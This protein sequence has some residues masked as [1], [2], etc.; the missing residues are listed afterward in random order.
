MFDCKEQ[1]LRPEE[2][3]SIFSEFVKNN[4]DKIEAMKIVLERPKDWK[5]QVLKELKSMLIEHHFSEVKIRS[6]INLIYHKHLPDII[7]IIKNAATEEP[8]MDANERV[9]AAI[10]N[11][12]KGRYL[13]GEQS[14]WIGY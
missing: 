10:K 5:T 2:Y 3:L 4:K 12:F 1:L 14:D 8:L 7:S 6:A 13:T 9:E 11:L